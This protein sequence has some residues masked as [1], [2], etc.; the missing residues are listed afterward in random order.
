[1]AI[2]EML[3]HERKQ[4]EENNPVSL[5]AIRRSVNK[6]PAGV[7][8]SIFSVAPFPLTVVSGHG[9]K[10]TDID[11]HQRVDYGNGYGTTVFGHAN[12]HIT[13][14]IE[15]RVRD[16][17]FF[18][19]LGEEVV[20]WAEMMAERFRLDWIR[21]SNSGTEANMDAIRIARGVT[22]RDKILKVEGA[23]HGTWPALFISTSPDV[24]KAKTPFT[25][26]PVGQGINEPNTSVAPFNNLDAIEAILENQDYA[27]L[28][29]EPIL[30]NVGA[31]FPAQAYL[32]GLREIC[33]QT[34]T[35]LVFDEVKTGI[36][37]ARGGAEEFFDVTPDMKTFGKGIAG[38]VPAGAIGGIDPQTYEDIA[39]WKVPHLGTFAGNHLAAAAGKAALELLDWEAYLYL[40]QHRQYL[41]KGLQTVIDQYDLPCYIVGAGAKNCVVWANGTKLLNF[42]DYTSRVSSPLGMLQWAFLLNRGLWLTPGRDEQTTHSI[43]HDQSDADL[44]IRNFEAFAEALNQNGALEELKAED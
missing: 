37:I 39:K 3:E 41:A 35:L 28:I 8:S 13:A 29:I 7:P 31:I 9:S 18:G 14:A 4:I 40:D 33:D 6:M 32:S 12:P 24:T 21:F 5:A 15:R 43:M 34:G 27:A 26:V 17:I 19:A 44:Y 20:D 36:S 30:F 1:M 25:P 22:G 42:R 16:G 23:Y 2:K 11:G 38:G 10:I